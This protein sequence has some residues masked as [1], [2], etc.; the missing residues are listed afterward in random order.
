MAETRSVSFVVIAYNEQA[1]I[2]RCLE[3]IAAQRGLSQVPYEIV[4][5][6]DGSTDATAQ[7]VQQFADQHDNVHFIDLGRNYGRG[8][9]RD[10]GVG[11]AVGDLVATIDSDIVLPPDWL[12][13]ATAGLG[14]HAAVGGVAVPDGDVTYLYRRFGLTPRAVSPTTTVTGNNG[15]F[16]RQVFDEVGYEPGLREGEDVALNHAI[17]D[18]GWTSAT[19][20]DLLVRHEESKSFAESMRWLYDSGR[21][22]TR[23]LLRYRQVRQPDLATAAMVGTSAAGI[24]L[25]VNGRRALGTSLPAAVLLGASLQHVRGRFETSPSQW[26]RVVPAVLTDCAILGAYFVGRIAG[27]ASQIAVAAGN[28]PSSSGPL[29]SST[30]PSGSGTAAAETLTTQV[31]PGSRANWSTPSTEGSQASSPSP[32]AEHSR[33]MR[34]AA[35]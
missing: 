35:R 27:L 16:R 21:G 8:H 5:V 34:S 28:S 26:P 29:A 9:A 6:N 3:A 4:V 11:A 30:S 33:R 20:P 31:K 19:I 13:R 10:R 17:A 2:G 23:Q 1:T 18:R 7:L 15:L 25:A 12:E 22:A 32:S 14:D 24:A